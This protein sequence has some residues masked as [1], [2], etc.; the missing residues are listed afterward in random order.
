MNMKLF[1]IKSIK[2]RRK[3]GEKGQALLIVLVLMLVGIVIIT[4]TLIFMGTTLKTNKVYVDNTTS[5]YAAE[6]G[7]QDGIWN[8]LN[9]TSASLAGLL[10]TVLNNPLITPSVNPDPTTPYTD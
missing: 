5:L 8:I 6:A 1:Q 9:N 10:S 3:T 2:K 7:I 4:S